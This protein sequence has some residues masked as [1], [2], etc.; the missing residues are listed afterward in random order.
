MTEAAIPFRSIAGA[1]RPTPGDIVIALL[2]T[3]LLVVLYTHYW[4]GIGGEGE[5]ARIVSADDDVYIVSLSEDSTLTVHG[6]LGD[7]V[8]EIH[9]GRIRFTESPCQGKQCI[10]AGW[11][12]TAGSFAACLPNR[13]SVTVLGRNR[14]FDSINY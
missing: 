4:S 9:Q 13:V 10:H 7:S 6:P 2:A 14:H 12:H 3:V 1:L 11:L 8:I 5:R